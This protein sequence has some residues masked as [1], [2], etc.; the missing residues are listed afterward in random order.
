MRVAVP[1]ESAA[2][3]RRVALVPESVSKLR[4]AGF[5][6]RV[7]RGAGE[8]AGFRDDEYA[9]AGAELVD[10]AALTQDVQVLVGVASP[11]A[12]L[13]STLTKG[14]VVV[15]FLEPLTDADGIARL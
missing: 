4:D 12:E 6:L 9:A 5:E 1:R 3:E 14:T 7:E 10:A 15:G 11:S 2:D 13:V 8:A